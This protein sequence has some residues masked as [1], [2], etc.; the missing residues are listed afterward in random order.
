[1]STTVTRVMKHAASR[2]CH[3]VEDNVTDF[4]HGDISRIQRFMMGFEFI[5]SSSHVSLSRSRDET[6]SPLVHASHGN[7]GMEMI[8]SEVEGCGSDRSVFSCCVMLGYVSN[9]KRG[10][11]ASR[12]SNDSPDRRTVLVH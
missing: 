11:D 6:I 4:P 7:I 2:V 12:V 9:G 5:V 1:M 3:F 8:S 10:F